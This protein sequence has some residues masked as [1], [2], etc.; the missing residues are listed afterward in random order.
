MVMR[1]NLEEIF[2]ER[3]N[4]ALAVKVSKSAATLISIAADLETTPQTIQRWKNGDAFP[5]IKNISKLEAYFEKGS[6]WFFGAD[7]REPLGITDAVEILN[8]V[9]DIPPE[10]LERVLR[11]RDWKVFNEAMDSMILPMEDIDPEEALKK[12]NPKFT[13]AKD[14]AGKKKA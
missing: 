5:P 2:T 8:S 1:K 13:P 10:S 6:G 12:I 3:I 14:K 9:R 7:H 4:E 11:V